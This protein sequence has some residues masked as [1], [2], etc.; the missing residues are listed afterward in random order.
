M[1]STPQP[2]KWRALATLLHIKKIKSPPIGGFR[3]YM[4]DL[5]GFAAQCHLKIFN[6]IEKNEIPIISRIKI[7][8]ATS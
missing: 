3:G 2:P 5:V 1:V 8:S 6:P 4:G 7:G